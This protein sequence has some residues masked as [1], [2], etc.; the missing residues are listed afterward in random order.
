[1]VTFHGVDM[2]YRP[3]VQGGLIQENENNNFTIPAESWLHGICRNELDGKVY[4][5]WKV[6]TS[7]YLEFVHV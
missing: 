6:F 3:M 4:I 7:K 1:M 2:F 5:R